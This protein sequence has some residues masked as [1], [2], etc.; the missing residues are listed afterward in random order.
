MPSPLLPPGK[1]PPAL[2]RE[3]L[4][5]GPPPP[6][7]LR[8]PPAIG[9]DGC[10][11]EVEGGVLVAATDPI[12]LTGSG[13][14]AHAVQVNANDVAVMGASPRWFLAT[15]VLPLGTREAELR[16]LFAGMHAALAEVGA[17][18]VGGHTEVSDAV[19]RPLVVGQ[20]LGFREDGRFVK[21]GGMQ[22]GD[23]VMQI[24]AAPIEGAAVLAAEAAERL[25]ALEA[26]LLR[27]AREALTQPGIS[28]VAAALSATALGATALHDPTEGG[29]SSGL[30]E[31]AE[32][33][34]LAIVSLDE[35]AVPWFEPG[36]A[37]CREVG[38]NPWGTLA[39]GALLASFPADRAE[40]AEAVLRS[41]DQPVAR[42]ARAEPGSGVTL[43]SGAALPRF[44][45]D[46]LSRIL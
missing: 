32:A 15:I 19:S 39:S 13:V 1:V 37:I 33:S 21:T 28:V 16:E 7:E 30:Y 27:E 35:S 12:T 45:R 2:L 22:P 36:L 9:E 25:G 8:V 6:P 40:Q 18:L 20:M 17:A 34:G 38:A 23:V 26:G 29:L 43:E 46:E 31:L 41:G 24:G 42:I 14:G 5:S 4:A 11:I 10:V 44:S 3:L